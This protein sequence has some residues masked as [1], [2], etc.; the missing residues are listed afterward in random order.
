VFK[1]RHF[2]SQ[3]DSKN[4][5]EMCKDVWNGTDYLPKVATLFESD[6]T[7]DFV[8]MEAEATGQMIAAGNRRNFDENGDTIWLEA[9]R[10]SD[11]FKGRGVATA[12]MR[13]LIERSRSNGA[14]EVLACTV[15]DNLAMK[16]VFSRVQMNLVNKVQWLD[17][18]K[19]KSL[20]GWAATDDGK[21]ENILKALNVE[22]LVS[23][24]AKL[25]TWVSVGSE[26]ELES[27]LKVMTKHGGIGHLPGL[28]K[29]LWSSDDLRESIEK[30][31]VRT[32]HRLKDSPPAVM[33]LVKDSAIQSLRSK[34]VCSI[35]ATSAHDFESALW[36]ACSEEIKSSLGSSPAFTVAFDGC[37]PTDPGT[38][39]AYLPVSNDNP[40]VIYRCQI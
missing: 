5:T 10:V 23:E 16:K 40:F 37:I 13:E 6:P 11:K 9:I 31:M 32:L 17:F 38:L 22:H 29:L 12:L 3:R 25:D 18:E 26:D 4:L 15:N 35:A 36:E 33:A 34:Y 39:S 19:M 28:G 20:P 14:R 24:P 27:L 2:S 7:C 1:V 21:A 30:G 8:I